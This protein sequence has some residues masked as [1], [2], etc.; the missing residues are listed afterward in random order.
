MRKNQKTYD[1]LF[2]IPHYGAKDGFIWKAIE[3][4][5]HSPGVLSMAAF[6]RQNNFNVLVFDCNLEQI[7][8]KDFVNEFKKRYSNYNFRFI[9]V[10]TATQTANQA[11]RISFELKKIL[12]YTKIV[13]GGPHP[14]ALPNDVLENSAANFVVMGEGE[15]LILDILNNKSNDEIKGLAYKNGDEIIVNQASER[16]SLNDDFP[17][18]AYDLVPMHLCKPLIASYKKLPATIMLTARGCPGNCTFCSRT[19]GHQLREMSPKRIIKELEVLYYEYGFRQ[20]I[21]YD[22]TFISNRER[23]SE[24]CDLLIES[25]MKISWTCSSRVDR[26]Y[27]DLLQ[28]MKNAGCHQIMYGV[29]SFNDDVLKNINKR[30]NRQDILFAISETRKVGIEV[31]AALMLGNKGDTEE[32]LKEN[33]KCLK[34][35]KPDLLQLTITTPLPGSK[36]FQEASQANKILTYNWDDYEGDVQIM[37]HENLDYKTLRKYYRKTYMSFYLRPSFIFKTLFSINS[38]QALK[39]IM[40]GAVAISQMFFVS[41]FKSFK[42]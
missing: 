7:Q 5:F 36:I 20:I 41:I 9:G 10:S 38:L 27:P 19:M 32:I 25:E 12:P 35:T 16:L 8:E 17:L 13:F 24:F 37:E 34:K 3:Y 26:V 21:F 18:P 31:R 22:D 4:R 30:T 42:R 40:L 15:N 33:L 11:Y 2:V 14:T 39:T 23:I 6:L 29:E 28:K 1:I